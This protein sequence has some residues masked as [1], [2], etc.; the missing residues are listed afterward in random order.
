[1]WYIISVS[2]SLSLRGEWAGVVYKRRG[3]APLEEQ[4]N[5]E[6]H[7]HRREGARTY[8]Y[9]YICKYIIIYI[10]IYIYQYHINTYTYIY[11]YIHVCIYIYIY[12]YTYVHVEQSYVESDYDKGCDATAALK[13]AFRGRSNRDDSACTGWLEW[14]CAEQHCTALHGTARRGI[15]RGVHCV[16]WQAVACCGVW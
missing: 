14:W 9:I 3:Q 16:V 10:Y 11:I 5:A 13:C 1:M 4:P 15:A 6:T 7:E 8:I 12:I 2:L